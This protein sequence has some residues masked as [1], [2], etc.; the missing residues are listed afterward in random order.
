[1]Q[2]LRG[3]CLWDTYEERWDRQGGGPQGGS[4]GDRRGNKGL[5]RQELKGHWK[6]F[7]FALGEL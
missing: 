3:W 1:M 4:R 7:G 6:D 5:L 2:R